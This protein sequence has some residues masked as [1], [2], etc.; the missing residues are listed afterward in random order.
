VNFL[1][2]ADFT[3]NSFQLAVVADEQVQILAERRKQ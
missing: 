1:V 3:S 2:R